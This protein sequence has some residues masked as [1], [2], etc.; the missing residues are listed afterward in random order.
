MKPDYHFDLKESQETFDSHEALRQLKNTRWVVEAV[1]ALLTRSTPIPKRPAVAKALNLDEK[2]L[3]RFL[4]EEKSSFTALTIQ[5][6]VRRSKILLTDPSIPVPQIMQECGLK[7]TSR[8]YYNSI[9]RY[10]TG[11]LPNAYRTQS[12]IEE[13]TK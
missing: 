6:R 12:I 1:K 3:S 13:I 4:A 11:M 10:H 9:F 5:E 7:P 8:A 2:L